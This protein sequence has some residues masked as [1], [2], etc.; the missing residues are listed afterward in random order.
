MIQL[1]LGRGGN[2]DRRARGRASFFSQAASRYGWDDRVERP[3]ARHSVRDKGREREKDSSCSVNKLGAG[4]DDVCRITVG[5]RTL[6][7]RRLKL[8]AQWL[9]L[10]WGGSHRMDE[11]SPALVLVDCIGA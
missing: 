11:A 3:N 5:P 7:C 1:Q 9:W 6:Q 10:A 4:Q 2:V 8:L